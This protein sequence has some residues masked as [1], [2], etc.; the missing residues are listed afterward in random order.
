MLAKSDIFQSTREQFIKQSFNI[1]GQLAIFNWTNIKNLFLKSFI[2]IL[3]SK[4][5]VHNTPT[6]QNLG[7]SRS[8]NKYTR[9]FYMEVPPR[10]TRHTTTSWYCHSRAMCMWKWER[11]EKHATNTTYVHKILNLEKVINAWQWDET[12]VACLNQA[13]FFPFL[14]AVCH[15]NS[16]AKMCPSCDVST[17]FA[18]SPSLFCRRRE[19]LGTRSALSEVAHSFSKSKIK[20]TKKEQ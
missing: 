20:Y 10:A 11:F 4:T 2:L 14:V 17:S 16:T 1:I 18:G 9:P 7:T 19:S 12:E 13:T 6:K 3:G 8:S 15:T 5:R